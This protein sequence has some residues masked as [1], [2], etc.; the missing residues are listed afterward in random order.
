[1]K[2]RHEGMRRMRRCSERLPHTSDARRFTNSRAHFLNCATSAAKRHQPGRVTVSHCHIMVSDSARRMPQ[3]HCASLRQPVTFSTLSSLQSP[4]GI[5]ASRRYVSRNVPS[6][7][8]S[9]GRL[10][11]SQ[12]I[13][14]QPQTVRCTSADDTDTDPS[15]DC[16]RI[17]DACLY[18]AYH[19]DIWSTGEARRSSSEKIRIFVKGSVKEAPSDDN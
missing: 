17:I 12:H 16:V 3:N 5:V 6:R 18:C 9:D 7:S 19:G 13:Q 15:D 8:T 1:M 4:Q 2:S 14:L 10:V 11:M